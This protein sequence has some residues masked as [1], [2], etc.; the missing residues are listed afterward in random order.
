MTTKLPPFLRKLDGYSTER[1]EVVVVEGDLL[2]GS[3]LRFCVKPEQVSWIIAKLAE[4][5]REAA[6]KAGWK[7]QPIAQQVDKGVWMRPTQCGLIGTDAP[8]MLHLA[9][10]VGPVRFRFA[11]QRSHA[12]ELGR[13]LLAA[14]AP[15]DQ[16]H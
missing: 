9:I 10:D 16:K 8:D 6:K 14:A 13:T 11:L 5:T 2:D 1:G 12:L 3:P 15:Q 7:A 4:W